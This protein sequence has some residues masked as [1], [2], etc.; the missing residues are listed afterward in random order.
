MRHAEPAQPIAKAGAA[1]AGP[2]GASAPTRRLST[3]E[4]AARLLPD[5]DPPRPFGKWL[6]G[7]SFEERRAL[8]VTGDV[9]LLA[10]LYPLLTV[11]FLLKP[12]AY[13]VPFGALVIA[14]YVGACW[15]L[16]LYR[17]APYQFSPAMRAR[18]IELDAIKLFYT[19][20]KA[21][22]LAT[23]VIGTISFFRNHWYPVQ[24]KAILI[25]ALAACVL[26]TLWRL[27]FFRL[28]V[29]T[30]GK[31]RVLIVG[32]GSTAQ[33]IALLI[34]QFPQLGY[35]VVGFVDDEPIFENASVLGLP[36]LGTSRSLTRL[37]QQHDCDTVVIGVKNNKR[38]ETL[39]AIA[40]CLVVGTEILPA[41]R[42]YERFFGIVPMRAVNQSWFVYELSESDHRGLYLTLKRVTDVLGAIAGL[43]LT[44]PVLPLIALAIKL[45]SPGS[46]LYSQ[47]R[48]GR[49][50]VP[51][52]IYKF[53]SMRL[54]AEAQGP[55][56]AQPGDPRVTRVG[57][58]L[59]KT[60]LDELPQLYNVI[61]GELSLV[62]PR[63]ERPEFVESLKQAIPY[64]DRR[65][66]VQ[67]GL[68]GWA[69]V[70]FTYGASIDDSYQKLQYDFYYIKNRSLILDLEIVLRTIWVVLTK[71]G[72]Q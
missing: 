14:A 38:L 26:L 28:F 1:Q 52:R 69:Q 39:E 18:A 22:L 30:F 21:S 5:P 37:V 35:E 7:C 50:H 61:R 60:R 4:R 32:A 51:F 59:R 47:I 17:Q 57:R 10:W 54:D 36:V 72:A 44:A 43:I 55:A 15:M 34:R 48:V 19:L 40:D 64:Y 27:F 29:T 13:M 62:G 2:Y 11:P 9:L 45:E 20:V 33:D 12:S 63:P 66:M 46:V 41:A 31:K 6:R 24:P 71:K 68:T 16:D 25:F 3:E 23:L 53:R 49:G 56:W 67:P 8:L 42:L 65:H 58:W 70:R